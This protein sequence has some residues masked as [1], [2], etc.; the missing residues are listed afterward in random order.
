MVFMFKK[1]VALNSA[2][3][4][5]ITSR[6]AMLVSSGTIRFYNTTAKK[7]IKWLDVEGIG[8]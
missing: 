1:A 2:F 3:S 6:E 7:F 4:D 5:F 8:I